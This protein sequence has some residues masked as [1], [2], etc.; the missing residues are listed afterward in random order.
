MAWLVQVIDDVQEATDVSTD[1]SKVKRSKQMHQQRKTQPPHLS[2]LKNLDDDSLVLSNILREELG[3]QGIGSEDDVFED[4]YET[5]N[6]TLICRVCDKFHEAI[7][8]IMQQETVGVVV[9][10]QKLG[11][12]GVL[13]LVQIVT[14]SE[15][16]IFDILR[17]GDE[18]FRAGL[19][20]VFEADSVMKVIHDCRWIADLLRYQHNV[21]MVNI[22]DTQVANAFVYRS[23]NEGDWPRFVESLPGCLISHLN[24]SP[25]EVQFT[26]IRERCKEKDEAVWLVRPLPEK[27]LEAATKNTVHLLRLQHVLLVQMLAEFRAAVGI[28]LNHVTGTLEDVEKCRATS[29]LLPIAFT[30]VHKY[31]NEKPSCYERRDP[32]CFNKKG[33]RE[34]NVNVPN[35]DVVFSHDS[36]WHKPHHHFSKGFPR[37]ASTQEKERSSKVNGVP[38]E[39]KSRYR[40]AKNEHSQRSPQKQQDTS[41]HTTDCNDAVRFQEGAESERL[42]ATS[43][44]NPELL[45][46]TRKPS[47]STTN[48]AAQNGGC[49]GEERSIPL[50]SCEDDE[51]PELVSE[52]QSAV[53]VDTQG[54]EQ[55]QK[56]LLWKICVEKKG[57]SA[58]IVSNSA[59]ASPQRQ[60]SATLGTQKDQDITP[61]V[62]S[63]S[64]AHNV[65]NDEDEETKEFKRQMAILDQLHFVPANRATAGTNGT[66]VHKSSSCEQSDSSSSSKCNQYSDM[67]QLTKAS[68]LSPSVS[69]SDSDGSPHMFKP[70]E[71]DLKREQNLAASALMPAG[72]HQSGRRKSKKGHR[73]GS[74][75][76]VEPVTTAG[77]T[78]EVTKQPGPDF[79]AIPT[80]QSLL[81]RKEHALG[82]SPFGIGNPFS[83]D[84]GFSTPSNLLKSRLVSPPDGREDSISDIELDLLL[85]SDKSQKILKL[86][87]LRPST[88]VKDKILPFPAKA[89]FSKCGNS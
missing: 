1:N 8:Y 20:A 6:Y 26:Q 35:T 63:L 84:E 76:A 10:G 11:R 54:A 57:Q 56:S 34:N 71:A 89:K 12:D 42:E 9:D 28:Y 41:Q 4:F 49:T 7:Q 67:P 46:D 24:L 3:D 44:S 72:M 80:P 73:P 58:L 74:D 50:N 86:A 29:H 55:I 87:S 65:I 52:Q 25:T 81:Q 53:E 15:L 78:A 69:S 17:L 18:A 48:I 45:T 31:V 16:I 40:S 43:S 47:P 61:T 5:E 66:S 88:N 79:S 30:Y 23:L 39:E 36:P 37:N 83:E 38:A 14:D 60:V 59:N 85:K 21:S 2:R 68:Q 32:Q 64:P 77:S 27:L 19:Q 82:I 33:F 22:F 13:S 75:N 51:V 70:S 62:P